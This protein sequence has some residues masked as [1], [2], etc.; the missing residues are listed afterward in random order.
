[1]TRHPKVTGIDVAKH[2]LDVFSAATAARARLANTP[3][4]LA[5]F[6][7]QLPPDSLVVFEATG[8]YDMALRQALA[9]AG[10]A[11][12]RVNP[13][14]RPA[15]SP[16]RSARAPRPTPSMRGFWRSWAPA[17]PCGA[18]KPPIRRASA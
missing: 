2:H 11:S 6:T 17:C 16:G 3:A 4:A 12:A 15:P 14:H 13:G 9:Q 1:M 18:R 5:A 10:L 7:R 8:V